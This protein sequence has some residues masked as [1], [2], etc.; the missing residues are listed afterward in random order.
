MR[1]SLL[2]VLAAAL[3]PAL[4]VAA[5]A[6][7]RTKAAPA[8]SSSKPWP[9]VDF[10]AAVCGYAAPVPLTFAF[11]AGYVSRDPKHGAKI[12]CFWATPDDLDRILADARGAH[13]ENIAH[14]VF[15]N[16]IPSN[17]KFDSA[18]GK[19]PDEKKLIENF[20]GSGIVEPRVAHR[21]FPGNHPGLVL[22]GSAASKTRVYVLYLAHG[23]DDQVV[24][25]NYHSP[26]GAPATDDPVWA[27]FLDS[28]QAA[29]P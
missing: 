29:K 19:F 13:F 2:S 5:P 20:V 6:P 10:A 27:K 26:T 16:R 12:G 14:G 3:V 17:M 9:R 7:V 18:T 11:P 15:W 24:I 22:T 25:I 1:K 8:F 28:I 4:C 23:A 21:T